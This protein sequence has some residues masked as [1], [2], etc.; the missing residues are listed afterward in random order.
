MNSALPALRTKGGGKGGDR[1]LYTQRCLNSAFQRREVTAGG[2]DLGPRGKGK[3]PAA[4]T[5]G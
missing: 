3:G 2:G 4:R 5:P 1:G